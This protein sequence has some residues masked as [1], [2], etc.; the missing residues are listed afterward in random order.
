[1]AAESIYR[2]WV[3]DAGQRPAALIVAAAEI[4]APLVDHLRR[5]VL[6]CAEFPVAD[7]NGLEALTTRL[8]DEGATLIAG[9][10]AGAA[11][12]SWQATLLVHL[13]PNSQALQIATP[14]PVLLATSELSPNSAQPLVSTHDGPLEC[15]AIDADG[16]CAPDPELNQHP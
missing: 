9:G 15:L 12:A 6:A 2:R 3:S 11:S 5:R 4:Y 10:L 8:L 7:P 14:G 16:S 13:H 1:M